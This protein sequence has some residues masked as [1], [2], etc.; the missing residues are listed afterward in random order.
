[1]PI[2][3][4]KFQCCA[5]GGCECCLCTEVPWG[6]SSRAH[7]ETLAQPCPRGKHPRC[8][9]LGQAKLIYSHEPASSLP[10]TLQNIREP[11]QRQSCWLRVALQ[12]LSLKG[13]LLLGKK[14][15]SWL[16]SITGLDGKSWRSLEGRK[17]KHNEL[18][19]QIRLCQKS[20]VSLELFHAVPWHKNH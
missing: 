15:C 5:S 1:M 13:K 11:P 16:D 18:I 7:P 6:H 3:Q 17:S 4:L 20:A 2:L 19:L 10:V 14:Y 12:C 9:N 8:L